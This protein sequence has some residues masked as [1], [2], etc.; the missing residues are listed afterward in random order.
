MTFKEWLSAKHE[1]YW[2]VANSKLAQWNLASHK[3]LEYAM[4]PLEQIEE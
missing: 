3:M 4:E 2:F 1:D